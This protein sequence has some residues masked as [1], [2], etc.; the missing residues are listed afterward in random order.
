MAKATH[1]AVIPSAGFSHFVPII[2]FSKLLVNLHPHIHLTCIIPIL[3]SL[4]TA[5]KPI[6]QTLPPR[7]S[8]IFLPPVTLRH[9]PQ[10][11]PVVLQIQHAMTLSMPSIHHT[12]SSITSNTPH[13]AMVVDT[14]AHEA[15][16]FA[17]EFNMLSYVYFPSA[18]TTL[19]THFY[20]PTLDRE[21]FCEYRD[22][23]HPITVPGC[24]PFHGRDLY[25][26]AQ[27]RKSEFYKMS[28]KRYESYRFVDGIF[29]NSFLELETGP[30][31][32]FTDEERGYPPLYPVGPII[33]TGTATAD[34]TTGLECLTWLDK[35]QDGSVLYVCFGSGGTLSQEQ[36][37]ELAHGLELSKHKFLWVVRAPSDEANAGYLGGEKD[38]DPLEFLPSGFLERTKEQGM[39]VPSWA[40]QIEILGHG[41][42]GGFLSHCGWNSTLESV[43][44]GVPLITW[45][46]F[47]EQRMNA[48]V[49]SEGLKVGVRGRV[50]ENG[51]VERVE[52]VEMI[53]CLME[54]EEGREMRKRVKE[55]KEA[56]TNAL[57]P[58][59]AATTILSQ[60]AHKWKVLAEQK[61]S[62]D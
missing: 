43:V 28:L 40:P 9:L 48:V 38:A 49:M 41:S 13:V 60:V 50:S 23:P 58:D 34:S 55:L 10:G 24:V 32:A 14:F 11:V 46:L 4:P 37:N 25:A 17:R 6:L 15:L 51:L 7:I 47:A 20:L 56:A 30:I 8:T 12:L 45:P 18:A 35:Q 1:I 52:I 31:R 61:I 36:M 54:E 42:V 21:T 57:K 2:N 39:V 5:A 44:H 16:H 33:Q 59:G 19:C 26:Q 29:I 62:F 53:K 27:D 22:L 3:G